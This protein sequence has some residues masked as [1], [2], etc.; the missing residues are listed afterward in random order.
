MKKIIA[1]T[2]LAVFLASGVTFGAGNTEATSND[3]Q[4]TAN[5]TWN[6]YYTDYSYADGWYAKWY[7]NFTT[8]QQ[9]KETYNSKNELISVKYYSGSIY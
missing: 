3:T 8:G 6:W 5:S 7:K 1:A 9:K 4:I 2:S